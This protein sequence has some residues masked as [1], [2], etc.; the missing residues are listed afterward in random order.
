METQVG[1]KE[2]T[3]TPLQE[4]RILAEEQ[5]APVHPVHL[6]DRRDLLVRK[7]HKARLAPLGHKVQQVDRILEAEVEAEGLV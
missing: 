2:E 7:V 6:K 5:G 1:G 3:P 4:I